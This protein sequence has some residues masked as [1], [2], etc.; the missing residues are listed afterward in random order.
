MNRCYGDLLGLF[1]FMNYSEKLKD[2][3]WQKKRLEIF[4]RDNFQCIKCKSGVKS[5]HIHHVRY[6][7]NTEPWDYS[8]LDLITLCETCHG[9]EHN[10]VKELDKERYYEG[11]LIFQD[12]KNTKNAIQTQIDMLFNSLKN[13]PEPDLEIEIMKNIIF[14]QDKRKE[15]ING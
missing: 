2:P 9:V 11:L 3:R 7:K 5:L 12:E 13:N 6:K 14:L 1:L 4:E 15:L 10:E 8:N